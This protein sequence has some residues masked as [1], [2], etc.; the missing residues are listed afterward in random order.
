LAFIDFKVRYVLV[1]ECY[2]VL[3]LEPGASLALVKDAY[4]NLAKVWHPDL[5]QDL[6]QKQQA[7]E[8]IKQINSAY[9]HLKKNYQPNS[10]D[11]SVSQHSTTSSSPS[12]TKSRTN[13]SDLLAQAIDQ[14]TNRRYQ[15][16]LENLNLAIKLNPD[17]IEAFDQRAIVN[18]QLGLEDAEIHDLVRAD[19][20]RQKQERERQKAEAAAKAKAAQDRATSGWVNIRQ[21]KQQRP[22]PN[23]QDSKPVDSKPVDSK[24]SDVMDIKEIHLTSLECLETWQSLQQLKQ[25]NGIG[26]FSIT[27]NCK[28]LFL[29]DKNHQI[30]LWNLKTGSCFG[31]LTGHQNQITAIAVSADDQMLVSADQSG[32]VNIWHLPTASQLKTLE[33]GSGI[34]AITI[35]PQREIIISRADGHLSYWQFGSKQPGLEIVAHGAGICQLAIAPTEQ[36]LSTTALDNSIQL[37]KIPTLKSIQTIKLQFT[38]PYLIHQP[39]YGWITGNVMGEIEQWSY[40]GQRQ[41][42]IHT[43]SHELRGMA[44]HPDG[45][46]LAFI[47]GKQIG[48]FDLKQNQ[49][50]ANLKLHQEPISQ[51]CFSGDGSKLFSIDVGGVVQ[52]WQVA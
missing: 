24:P 6:A 51:L 32:Q 25:D 50:T 43:Y 26:L 11:A 14:M 5:F 23:Q 2:K 18:H 9:E 21:N 16:A 1:I 8:K 49:L 34:T 19:R 29:A 38:T 42:A 27:R 30:E 15:E 7:E 22:N 40:S 12:F 36:L 47:L 31:S 52:V 46:R 17:F 28:T 3:E 41:Q 33:C 13:P 48:I 35:T 37:S 45:Q 10:S 39:H 20:L 44:L 4:R